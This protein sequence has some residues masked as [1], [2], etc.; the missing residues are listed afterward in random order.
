MSIKDFISKLPL[1]TII[2]TE[3]L[4]NKVTLPVVIDPV[5]FYDEF[6]AEIKA[7]TLTPEK[8]LFVGCMTE[9]T[10]YKSSRD[11]L[12]SRLQFV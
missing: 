1:E 5:E 12:S 9:Q 8:A 3:I 4:D 2:K 11:L 10:K 7:S 6:S